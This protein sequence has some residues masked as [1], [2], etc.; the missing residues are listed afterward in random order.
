M[1]S[2]SIGVNFAVIGGMSGLFLLFGFLAVR[3]STY[4]KR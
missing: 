2:V 3:Y 4:E 1:G